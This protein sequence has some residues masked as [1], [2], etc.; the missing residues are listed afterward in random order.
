M[1]RLGTELCGPF[2]AD[3]YSNNSEEYAVFNTEEELL[4]SYKKLDVQKEQKDISYK[5]HIANNLV[6]KEEDKIN[7][8]KNAIKIL[9]PNLFITYQGR[10]QPKLSDVEALVGFK[11]SAA[12]LKD[13]MDEVS[14]E[15]EAT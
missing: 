6:M 10:K 4:A 2:D 11:V 5:D 12:Q 8:I 13:A 3:I 7:S 15:S 14:D 9:P 1:R